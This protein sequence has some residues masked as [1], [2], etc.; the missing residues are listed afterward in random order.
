[1]ATINPF[2]DGG[3]QADA[4]L[5]FLPQGHYLFRWQEKAGLIGSKFVSAEDLQAAFSNS[6]RDTGWLALGIVRS[7]YGKQ[8]EWFVLHAPPHKQTIYLLE[9]GAITIPV[10]ALVLAGAGRSYSLWALKEPFSPQARIFDAPFPNIHSGGQICWGNNTPPVAS[11]KNAAAAWRLFFE[12]PFN[13]HLAQGKTRRHQDDVRKL[14][15]RLDGKRKFP[16]GE[17]LAERGTLDANIQRIFK[18]GE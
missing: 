16:T 13:S 8:G 2:Y 6:E 14:L 4:A 9:T 5:Y 7:G 18:Q 10:P 15:V 12:S 1:M 17:L 11:P 3:V